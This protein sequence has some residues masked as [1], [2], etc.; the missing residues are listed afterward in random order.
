[1]DLL[2]NLTAI[3]TGKRE[4]SIQIFTSRRKRDKKLKVRSCKNINKQCP[5]IYSNKSNSG[6]IFNS[7][8]A[9]HHF[10]IHFLFIAV[11]EYTHT[12]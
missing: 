4:V 7:D 8:L 11:F 12:V 2:I 9:F 3:N 10:D 6:S 5:S 1:M